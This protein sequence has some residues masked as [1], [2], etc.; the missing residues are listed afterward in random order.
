MNPVDADALDIMVVFDGLP[1]NT[2]AEP[3]GHTHLATEMLHEI[4]HGLGF[5]SLTNLHPPGVAV[6]SDPNLL[7]VLGDLQSLLPFYGDL[8]RCEAGFPTLFCQSFVESVTKKPVTTMT[9]AMAGALYQR[10]KSMKFGTTNT[11]VFSVD[12][13]HPYMRK[14][15]PFSSCDHIDEQASLMY[16]TVSNAVAS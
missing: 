11:P 13:R 12:Q 2:F 14:F 9:P 1:R 3:T 6:H 10:P 8:Q 15:T 16:W 4:C 7:N 5:L